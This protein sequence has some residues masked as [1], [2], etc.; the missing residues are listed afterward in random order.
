MRTKAKNAHLYLNF[1]LPAGIRVPVWVEMRGIIGVMRLRLQLT[2]D[3]PFFSLATIT[4]LGQPKADMSCVPLNYHAPNIMDVPFISS[5]VQSAI[6]AALAEYVAPKSLTLDLKNMLVGDDFKKDTIARGIVVVRIKRAR[7]FKEGDGNLGG[8]RKGS[9]DPYVTVGWSKFGKPVFASR[10]ILDTMQPEWHETAMIIVTPEEVNAEERLRIQ[11]WDSDKSTADDDLGRTE[12]G[13]KEL[14]AGK[15][16]NGKMVDHRDD[17]CSADVDEKMPG[18][19][20]YS[21]GYFRKTHI[22][23]DQLDAQTEEEDVQSQKDLKEKVDK[24]A[25]RK[26]REAGPSVMEGGEA[27]ELAQQK[28]Q[29]FKEREDNLLIGSPPPSKYCS[30]IFS[31]Q[32]HQITGLELESIQQKTPRH[33]DAKE[34][35]DE[36]E[37]SDDLPSSYCNI[38]INHSKV[39]K[40]RTKPKNAKPFFNAGT[41]RF[42]RDWR[43]T[44]VMLS[45]RDS[46]VHE[47]DPLLGI[48][49]LPLSKVFEH[50]SQVI[51]SYPL[52]GG[53]GYGRARVSMVFRALKLELPRELQGWD[54]GTLEFVD[55]PW[56]EKSKFPQDFHS[57]RITARTSI[58]KGK[59]VSSQARGSDEGDR[60][61]WSGKHNRSVCLAVRKRYA[62]SL[63]LEFRNSSAL[64]TDRTTAF[65]ILWLRDIPDDE[66]TSLTLPVYKN[67]DD[68]LKIISDGE[69]PGQNSDLM[70]GEIH[71]QIK[72]W[73][74]LSGFH[75]GLAGRDAN[76]RDVFEVLETAEDNEE[77]DSDCESLSDHVDTSESSSSSSDEDGDDGDG[78]DGRK[79]QTSV[80]RD[81]SRNPIQQ[82]RDYKQHHRLLHRQHRG[83][84]QWKVCYILVSCSGLGNVVVLVLMVLFDSYRAL[85]VWI[86]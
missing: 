10:V 7:E 38:I 31:I 13:L 41:E 9:S 76:L 61:E 19:I 72:F 29:D 17:L 16:T 85:V 60:V 56:I 64:G 25:E 33:N 53:I 43:S 75:K 40:T 34:S 66:A 71:L 4:F 77:T 48:V 8:L 32:I 1:Y 6:D 50:R 58:D 62:T 20:E 54:Y 30:G 18:W 67:H 3:P 21:I 28:A 37:D 45:V 73:H 83:I 51:D 49:Y 86:G 70:I 59:L 68:S 11:L 24:E 57:Q 26:L 22:T 23:K 78:S 65:A 5:F 15:E 63:V 44:E 47:N 84:M 46:R 14:M 39:Y 74:G 12:V 52:V 27:S 80:Q 2:P 42:I 79:R 35:S 82:A 69:I 55:S 36:Q 81:G